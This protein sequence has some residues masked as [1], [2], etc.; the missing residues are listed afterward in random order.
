MEMGTEEIFR[1]NRSEIDGLDSAIVQ[2]IQALT[3]LIQR[4]GE[5]AKNLGVAKIEARLPICD[6]ARE[7]EILA[8]VAQMTGYG[9]I[10]PED[11]KSIY[12][13]IFEVARKL[14]RGEVRM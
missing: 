11:M 5:C 10:S 3:T 13:R 8:R 4:R 12:G 9:P 1:K 14:Q 2:T 7:E 6:P